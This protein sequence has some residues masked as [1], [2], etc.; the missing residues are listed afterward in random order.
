[1]G[2]LRLW[3]IATYRDQFFIEPPAWFTMYLWME[4]LYHVPL[5]VWAIPALL[6]DDA[7][8]PVHLL[9]YAIQTALTTATCISDYLSWE[10][11]S[12]EVKVGLGGLYVPYLA[13]GKWL[14]Q[15][16]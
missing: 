15:I 2:Q 11:V 6:R 16:F 4:L 1:M 9:V 12:S 5:C 14:F 8:V 13:L 7:L 3:Y 10:G